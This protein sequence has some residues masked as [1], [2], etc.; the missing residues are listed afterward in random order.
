M[1][2][3]QGKT[4]GEWKEAYSAAVLLGRRGAILGEQMQHDACMLVMEYVPGR[5]L[6]TLDEPFTS[7]HLLRTAAELGRCGWPSVGSSI[8]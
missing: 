1:S 3:H 7:G 2:P 5:A 4:A 8:L 6:F